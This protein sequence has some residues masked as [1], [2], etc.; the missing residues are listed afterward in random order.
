[1]IPVEVRNRKAVEAAKY[2]RSKFVGKR[3]VDAD[4]VFQEAVLWALE[5][6]DRYG[7]TFDGENPFTPMTSVGMRR[8]MLAAGR[9]R[10]TAS[11]TEHGLR[12][13]WEIWAAVPI[14]DC[15][16]QDDDETAVQ[17]PEHRPAPDLLLAGEA[18][19]RRRVARLVADLQPGEHRLV[20]AV[21]EGQAPGLRVLAQRCGL[22]RKQAARV[23]RRL[24]DALGEDPIARTARTLSQDQRLPKPGTVLR[25][26][27]GDRE[28]ECRITTDGLFEYAGRR[29]RSL[30]AAA[31]DAS[32]DVGRPRVAIN[33][34]EFW[35][36]LGSGRVISGAWKNRR[37]ADEGT[38][39]A[40]SHPS[41]RAATCAP[42]AT[43][44]SPKPRRRPSGPRPAS[45]CGSA[46]AAAACPA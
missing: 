10:H 22:S 41:K 32:R 3:G 21:I 29:Y 37:N 2:V 24:A 39:A 16:G 1:M 46:R 14:T 33:G 12:S 34:F 43:S 45:T 11:I 5:W 7:G 31:L 42:S 35:G 4:D 25:R 26:R 20:R 36:L 44:P 23:L 19:R 17:V 15:G 13:G 9:G 27:V 18:A 6:A 8:A 38:P 30:S 40:T 28:V